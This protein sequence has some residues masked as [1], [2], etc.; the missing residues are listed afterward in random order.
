PVSPSR[1][2]EPVHIET[3]FEKLAG[4][5]ITGQMDLS[6]FDKKKPSEDK[7]KSKADKQKVKRERIQK[8]HRER[9]D[10][11]KVP[12]RKT[13]NSSRGKG[14]GKERFKPIHPE[15]DED[16]IQKQIKETYARMTEGKG[17]TKGS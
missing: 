5:K 6:Q 1:P 16:A 11:N 12:P 14:R 9:V 7:E 13:D 4:P 15:V 2:E 17:K 3:E 8:P 10:V